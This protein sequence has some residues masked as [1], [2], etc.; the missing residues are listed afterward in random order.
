MRELRI[1]DY[2]GM[3]NILDEA[4]A[5]VADRGKNYGDVYTNHERIAT[6]WTVL[7]G[8]EVKAEQVAMM[9][10]ALKLAR[11]VETP[12]H[13]DSWVDIAGYA[14]TGARCVEEEHQL[15]N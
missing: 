7:L 8:H 11:L 4:K 5:A 6:M 14:W 13:M 12:D 1:G 15:D 9:M 10:V 3:M 2:T